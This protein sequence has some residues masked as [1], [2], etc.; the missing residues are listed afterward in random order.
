MILVYIAHGLLIYWLIG[1]VMLRSLGEWQLDGA[2]FVLAWLWP[3]ILF[4]KF[5]N[6][7]ASR[8]R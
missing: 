7:L 6:I 8:K 5:V 2:F 3:I 4:G 1:A